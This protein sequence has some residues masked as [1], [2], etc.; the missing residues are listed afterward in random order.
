EKVPVWIADYV[1]ISYGTGAIM[2]VPAHDERD[3]EFARKF[4]VEI[5]QVVAAQELA[6]LDSDGDEHAMLIDKTENGF[7]NQQNT[8]LECAFTK[9]GVAINS[10]R[11]DG[12]PTDEFKK[13]IA[14]DLGAAGLCSEAVN[15]KLRDWLFSR[16]RYWG[17]P[18]P[19]WHELD[20][21]GN[22]TGLMRVDAADELPVVLPEMEKFK[23]TGTPEPML[24]TAP[25]SWLF[26]TADDGTK[27][28]RET[29]TMPQWAG[30][31]WYYLR[32]A[33]PK[34]ADCFLDPEV[35]KSWLPVDLYVGGAEHAVLHLLYAR[36]WHKVLFDRGHVST[37]EPFQ[38]LVNQ[39]MIL[40]AM[41]FQ[42]VLRRIRRER[43]SS[44]Q[45][46]EDEKNAAILLG[47]DSAEHGWSDL[48]R[49]SI[50]EDHP[51]VIA[52]EVDPED[53][54]QKD[55]N[56]VLS[57]ETDLVVEER[58][59]D[60]MPTLVT[61]YRDTFGLVSASDVSLGGLQAEGWFA[62]EKIVTV[63]ISE[64][65]VEKKGNVFVLRSNPKID[66]AARSAEKM[67]KSR[68][69]VINPDDVVKDYGADALR[70]YEMFMG[71]LEQVKPWSMKGVEGVYRFLARVWRMITDEEAD[72]I[73]LHPAV[74][75]ADLNEDQERILHK[76]IKAV[77]EDI[78]KLSFNTAISRMMEFTNEFSPQDVRPK[79]AME[80][81]TILLSPFAPH[82]AEE[83]WQLLGHDD[84]LAFEPWPTFDEAKIAE[85]EIEVPVQVNGKLKAK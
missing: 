21:D 61:F 56:T 10:G 5:K 12:T 78:E 38:K 55:G 82:M 68:G 20:A 24:S 17:E 80:T 51:R 52:E 59:I 8:P 72:E 39:G 1:L 30:S 15:F 32:F 36:F 4:D 13:K 77:T 66:V 33:D 79:S 46:E 25:E 64:S 34:N 81:L 75:E 47:E 28:K 3:F 50:S 67:S 23:P 63:N 27:L 62:G 22:E 35:E 40:G 65:D 6:D 76:T 44:T 71:P 85:A 37:C 43:V 19:I 74:Q 14:T 7:V 42:K 83:L 9:P 69:N 2:A 29:N 54:Q 18:F 70:L 48:Q 26:K 84:T 16:Q 31:C 41:Q 49:E 11:Y 58:L 53:V 73:R 60:G 57:S 45:L